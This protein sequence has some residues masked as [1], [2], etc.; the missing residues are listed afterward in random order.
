MASFLVNG[1]IEK[2][3]FLPNS[4][5]CV[6][7][8]VEFKRGFRKKSGEIVDDRYFHWKCLFKQSFVDFINSHFS[9]SMYVEV[10]GDILPYSIEKGEIV[11]PSYTVLAQTI[12]MASYPPL[13]LGLE[14]KNIKESQLHP[15]GNPNM[16]G[17]M[18]DDF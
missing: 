15:I 12:N 17:Y 6:V 13:S 11:E 10:K 5:G 8:V 16:D 18:E 4:G 7:W 14:Q 3:S 2:I 9:K 1:R